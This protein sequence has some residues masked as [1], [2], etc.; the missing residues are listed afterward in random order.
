MGFG[1]TATQV[2]TLA[3][4][5][6][7][8]AVLRATG[9]LGERD[10]KPLN[11]II[12]WVGLPAFIFR[13]VQKAQLAADLW[14]SV[15]VSWLVFAVVLALALAAARVLKLGPERTGAF[16]LAVSL[17]NTGY[18]GY[19]V[20]LALF[21]AAILPYSLFYDVFGTVFALVLVGLPLAARFGTDSVAKRH[22]LHELMTF[23][24]VPALVVGIALRGVHVWG[25]VSHGLDL[26]AS[27]VTPLIMLSVGISLKPAVVARSAGALGV[28]AVLRL[29]I[30]PALAVAVGPLL[31]QG[32]P[33]QATVLEAGMPTMMLTYVIGERY[34]LDT[35][36]IASA[37]FVTTVLAAITIPIVQS[38][39]F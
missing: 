24:A 22:L 18:I 3:A 32:A 38:V 4:I 20:T 2:L 21:G 25:P 5:V 35:D 27:L 15:A 13:A 37:I 36:F 1:V 17:G 10:S 31:L 12:I 11:A 9:L 7:V 26:L 16:A 8:G 14:R 33:L 39:A 19:P 30:A 6:V 34:G 29:A 23:P 28:L